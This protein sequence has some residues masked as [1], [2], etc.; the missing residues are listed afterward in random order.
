M[1]TMKSRNVVRLVAGREIMERIRTRAFRFTLGLLAVGAI[2]TVLLSTYGQSE[3]TPRNLRVAVTAESPRLSAAL[4]ELGRPSLLFAS[5][6]VY[7]SPTAVEDAVRSG[8]AD[9]GIDGST[10][11]WH[12]EVDTTYAAVVAGAVQTVAVH[13]RAEQLGISPAQLDAL[14]GGGGIS[15]R[16]L[17]PRARDRN[18]RVGTAT[19]GV[20]VLYLAIQ[21]SGT[22]LMSGLISEKS[23]RVVEVLLNHVRARHLLAGKI[24]GIGLVGLLQL[25]TA[26]AAG[27]ITLFLT[28]SVHVPRIPVDALVWFVVWFALG[29]AVYASL[30]AMAASLVSRQEDAASVTMPVMLPLIG[31]YLLSFAVVQSADTRLA[32]VLAIV[33]LSAPLIMPIRVAAG[34]PSP[35]SIVASVVVSVVTIVALVRVAGRLYSATLLR[36]GTRVSWREGLATMVSRRRAA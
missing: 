27:V 16:V 32:Q 30:F 15:N 4:A 25:A 24:I 28:R 3:D 23:T 1:S 5:V 12:R 34:H 31:C 21:M 2:G 7:G 29:Y 20:I 35:L 17:E 8:H 36:T 22:I 26:A 14:L 18:V 19:I 13:D 33:P 6:V 10:A 9:V 11:I